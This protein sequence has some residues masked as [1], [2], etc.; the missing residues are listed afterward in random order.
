MLKF[1]SKLN[2]NFM[3]KF[4]LKIQRQFTTQINKNDPEV[5]PIRKSSEAVLTNLQRMRTYFSIC[6]ICFCEK[7]HG[8]DERGNSIISHSCVL[9]F[10]KLDYLHCIC[11]WFF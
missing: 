7:H 6:C 8:H 3:L 5:A 11:K 4:D 9:G 2:F 10:A 1:S